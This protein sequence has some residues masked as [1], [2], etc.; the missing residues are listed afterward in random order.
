MDADSNAKGGEGD[1][2]GAGG[3]RALSRSGSGASA[4]GGALPSSTRMLLVYAAWKVRVTTPEIADRKTQLETHNPTTRNP[5]IH[6]PQSTIPTIPVTKSV[7]MGALQIMPVFLLGETAT[8]GLGM[9]QSHVAT[10]EFGFSELGELDRV[11]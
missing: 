3:P 8:G 2:R 9:G 7:H 4:G 5:T 10:G 1:D 6:N 11:W